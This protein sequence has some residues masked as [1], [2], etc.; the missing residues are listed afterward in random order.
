MILLRPDCLAFK[1][2]SG[3]AAPT[4]VHEVILE[5]AGQSW[6]ERETI[7]QAAEAVLHYFKGEKGQTIVTL[8]E[9]TEALH[10][11]LQ[12]IGL[13]VKNVS[14]GTP[15]ASSSPPAAPVATRVVEANLSAMAS[16]QGPSCELLFFARIRQAIQSE[17]D[18]TPLVFRFHG[19][20][21]CVKQLAGAKRWS[22]HC[23]SIKDQILGYLHQCLTA[24]RHGD[25]CVLVV[26]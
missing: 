13:E 23:Q 14:A 4:P 7:E 15:P 20:Q 21:D 26:R 1:D 12:G 3:E 5:L 16:E 22:P 10:Q 24:E 6:V 19:L 18:G 2:P 8:T 9:F 25:G 11:V 17:L